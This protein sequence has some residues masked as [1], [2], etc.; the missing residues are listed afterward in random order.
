M[1]NPIG[2]RELLAAGVGLCAS[3][4]AG[5]ALAQSSATA[6]RE[7]GTDALGRRLGGPGSGG[8]G[9]AQIPKRM[10]KTTMLFLTPPSWPNAIDIDHDQQRGFWVQEQRHDNKTEAAW[11]I[12]WN[13]KLLRTVT[14]NSKNTSGMCY[15]GGYVWSGANGVS[16]ID[17]PTPPINGIFQVDMD[18]KQISHRQIPFGPKDDGG[19]THGMAWQ[20]DAGAGKIWIF[21]N[22]LGS[23]IRI[24]PKT[25]EVDYQIPTTRMA[26]LSERLHGI[27]YDNGFIWQ[28]TG[29]QKQGTSGYEGYTP[30]L[31][32]YDIKTGRVVEIVE[33][34][35]GSCDIHDVAIRNG[36]F[37][38]VDAGEHPGWSIDK[39]AYQRPGFPPLNSPSAGYVFRI[40]LI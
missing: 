31:V 36:Q 38:G 21:A 3:L 23:L 37:Y 25:W 18:G 6:P 1:T 14:T 8:R 33:F 26:G 22:R 27:E 32:K 15:G 16:E 7:P 40:D 11:L 34:V 2:R 35:P 20:T 4:G 30:G 19:S 13:G 29:R 39:P 17:H 28:V 10:A 9:G 12:D 5:A 24:D